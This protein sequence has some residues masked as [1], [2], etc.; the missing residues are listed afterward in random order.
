[1]GQPQQGGVAVTDEVFP[2]S[3]SSHGR[4]YC[5]SHSLGPRPK[6]YALI[7]RDAKVFRGEQ[8]R[9]VSSPDPASSL[10]YTDDS[11]V[12]CRYH[13]NGCVSDDWPRRP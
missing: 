7:G 9:G 2:P 12:Q 6:T 5:L 11:A 4:V 8:F 3:S 1:M 13:T 10:R